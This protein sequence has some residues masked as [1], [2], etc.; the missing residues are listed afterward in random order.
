MVYL[1]HF[2]SS[3]RHCQH[4]IGYTSN[5]STRLSAHRSGNGS[6]LLKAVCAAGIEINIVRTWEGDRKLERKLKNQHK[7]S[8]LCPVCRKRNAIK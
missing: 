6:R 1:I 3:F 2:A 4:Y 8:G 5:L 7:A